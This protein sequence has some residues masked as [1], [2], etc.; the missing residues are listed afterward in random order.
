MRFVIFVIVNLGFLVACREPAPETKWWKGNLH[1]HSLWSDGDDYPEQVVDWYKS[2]DYHFLA[3]SDH[4]VLPEGEQ[5][6]DTTKGGAVE[7]MKI[8]FVKIKKDR[9][10]HEMLGNN[11]TPKY[12]DVIFSSHWM[13][14]QTEQESPINDPLFRNLVNDLEKE[15]AQRKKKRI[16]DKDERKVE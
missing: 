4:D 10:I 2:R 14:G 6:V 7:L 15:I 13:S 3:I 12:K 1:T 16:F 8:V 9:Q 5:F 11:P